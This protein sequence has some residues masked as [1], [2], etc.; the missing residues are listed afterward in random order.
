MS[1]IYSTLS[2]PGLTYTHTVSLSIIKRQIQAI[3]L[4]YIQILFPDS[5]VSLYLT[6]KTRTLT[7]IL[8]TA[9]FLHGCKLQLLQLASSMLIS[10]I[11]SYP[12]TPLQQLSSASRCV[13][14]SSHCCA[15]TKLI[16]QEPWH[17]ISNLPHFLSTPVTLTA[18]LKCGQMEKRQPLPQ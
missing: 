1:Y 2:A 12:G 9:G 4:H 10:H 7:N 18:L 6:K 15:N 13:P 3:E 5:R 14:S 16:S 8:V 11:R 17:K